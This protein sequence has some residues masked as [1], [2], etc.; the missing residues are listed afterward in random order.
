MFFCLPLLGEEAINSLVRV[1]SFLRNQH[2]SF[3][4]DIYSQAILEIKSIYKLEN[5]A[6]KPPIN[7]GEYKF[8]KAVEFFIPLSQRK[9]VDVV[10]L[11]PPEARIAFGM[12]DYV[13]VSSSWLKKASDEDI[14]AVAAHEISHDPSDF[15]RLVVCREHE[16]GCNLEGLTNLL[17]VEADQRAITLFLRSGEDPGSYLRS[18][19]KWGGE[20][21]K[22]RVKFLKTKIPNLFSQAHD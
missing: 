21:V 12:G 17:E 8:L 6:I 1:D 15:L 11:G 19:K 10:F 7:D 16:I 4:V 2:K 5:I 13:F 20:N 14:K 18:L 9:R 22:D 3:Y